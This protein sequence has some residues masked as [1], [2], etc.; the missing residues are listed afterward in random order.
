[1]VSVSLDGA[2]TRRRVLVRWRT[3]TLTP[4]MSALPPPPIPHSGAVLDENERPPRPPR[5]GELTSAWRMVFIVGWV[6][7]LVACGAVIRTSRTLGLSTWW[8]G[9]SSD[10]RFLLVQLLPFVPAAVLVVLAARNQRFLPYYG[11]VGAIML[12]AIATG[13]VHRFNRLA[14][15]EF[16]IAAAA[17]LV[18]LGSFAGLL[19]PGEPSH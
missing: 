7:V 10:P 15:L 14:A 5:P 6:C 17:L 9:P 11:A 16:I 1:M 8:L 3:A 12:A 19:R 18:S 2:F 13:D 4:A